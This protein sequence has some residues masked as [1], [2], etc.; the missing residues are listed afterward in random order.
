MKTYRQLTGLIL[1]ILPLLFPVYSI[2]APDP[3][4]VSAAASSSD[5][6]VITV[7]VKGTRRIEEGAIK[8]KLSQKTNQPLS[9]DKISED[10]KTIYKLGYFDDV[11]VETEFFEGGL[12]VIYIV[13]E[14]PTITKI[15]FYGND[16]LDDKKLKEKTTIT[17][18]SIS[19]N[20]LIQDNVKKLKDYYDG[21]GYY[22]SEIYPIVHVVKEG[23]VT[24]TFEIKE[25]PKL[26][27]RRVEFTGNEHLTDKQIKK[28]L[29]T[30]KWWI[31][32]FLDGTG[33]VK[34]DFLEEDV[35]NIQNLYMDYGYLNVKIAEPKVVVAEDGITVR[36]EISEGQPYNLESVNIVG[37][38]V[39]DNDNLSKLIT[40]KPGGV[41]S[42][43]QLN[44]SVK[45]ITDYYTQRGYATASVIPGVFPDEAALTVKIDMKVEE[46]KVYKIGTI[47]FSDNTKTRDKV[48]RREMTID[49]GDTF[50]SRKIE[51]SKQNI[52]NLDF[53]DSVDV[54]PKPQPDSQ[55][56]DVDVKVKEK[57]TGFISVGGGYS[58][59]DHIIG[60]IQL[61]QTNLF[62]TG[63]YARIATNF[64]GAS[65][66]ELSYKKPWF[67]DKPYTLSGSIYRSNVYYPN[68][69][70]QS[71][72]FVVGI[73]KRFWEYWEVGIG[74]R[75]EEDNIHDI[76]NT[77]SPLILSQE[78]RSSTGSFTPSISRD[79]RDSYIDPSIGSR[80]SLYVTVAGALGSNHYIKSG[81]DS[82][83]FFPF[84]GPTT[85]SIRGRYAYATGYAGNQLPL[86]E[87]FYV[88]GIQ[89]IRGVAFGN[90]GPRDSDGTYVGGT[91]ELLINN[92]V[93][94]PIFPEVKLKGVYFVDVGSAFGG[95]ITLSDI[96]YTTGAGVRW[97][98]PFGPIRVEYGV[99][100]RRTNGESVGRVEFSFGSFF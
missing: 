36:F 78:G 39:F 3:S 66:Y 70:R 64:G 99:N 97:I 63:D 55:I 72:G 87:R 77:S 22:L 46:G 43:G 96:K 35:L 34:K 31:L 100:L 44:Q 5:P 93:I 13:K 28:V 7:E 81:F 56:V 30:S 18:G 15:T 4:P 52:K 62:G 68:Y 90:A 74:Y 58:S 82:M 27:I 60:M 8:A 94:F 41:F 98:S 84:L 17:A 11:R 47:E 69:G 75:I 92:E 16:E 1:F 26:K 80:N 61:T 48:L 21:E 10:V 85:Y 91:S 50:D 95:D 49:E 73:S 54:A 24:L 71:T 20:T 88:G 33:F 86:Y 2:A 37:N 12:R 53:F 14:K 32:S 40:M 25:G 45:A 83:W 89:S 23:E 57:M 59:T 76:T 9:Q 67:M 79:T 38:T 42:K 19:D 65:L 51:R 29:N 6:L